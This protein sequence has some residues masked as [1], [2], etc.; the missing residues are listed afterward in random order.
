MFA[1]SGAVGRWFWFGLV[2]GGLFG[3]CGFLIFILLVRC[4]AFYGVVRLLDCGLV[5]TWLVSVVD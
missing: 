2:F 3:C 1:I 4:L 5:F